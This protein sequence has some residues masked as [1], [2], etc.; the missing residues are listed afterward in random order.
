[1]GDLV[2]EGARSWNSSIEVYI[3]YRANIVFAN[4]HDYHGLWA[5]IEADEVCL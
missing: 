4:K 3:I 5:S 2:E 1:M